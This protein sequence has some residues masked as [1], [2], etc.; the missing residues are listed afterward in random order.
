MSKWT[1]KLSTYDINYEPKN[2]IKSQAL[3]DFVADF[4]NDLQEHAG[5]EIE[6]LEETKDPWILFT[7]GASNVRGTGLGILLKSSQGDIISQSIACE[8][9]ATNNEAEYEALIAGPQLAKQM[10]I[11]VPREENVGADALENL[12]SSLKIPEDLK[13][14]IIHILHP[15]IDEGRTIT[16]L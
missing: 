8:F 2:A 10:K 13:I 7:D 11:R 14:P 9:Q 6:Q 5:L 3:A 1:V 4:T 16:N 15:A 12:T